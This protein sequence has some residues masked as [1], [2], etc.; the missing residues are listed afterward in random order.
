M[1]RPRVKTSLRGYGRHHQVLRAQ[2]APAVAAGT[3]KCARCGK[4]IRPGEPWDLDH[5]DTNRKRYLGP[6]HRKCNRATSGR[7]H[8]S[9]VW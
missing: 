2:V 8:Q 5:D 7:R 9:R 3:V 4:P 6:S 1:A